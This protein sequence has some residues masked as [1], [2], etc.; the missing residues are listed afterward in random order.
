MLI[1][2]RPPPSLHRARL[3]SLRQIKLG[4]SFSS[5]GS[6]SLCPRT[7]QAWL[8]GRIPTAK[9]NHFV[10][11][12][13]RSPFLHA[14]GAWTWWRTR[15]LS[16]TQAYSH[17]CAPSFPRWSTCYYKR[18]C[19]SLTSRARRCR[20]APRRIEALRSPASQIFVRNSQVLPRSNRYRR[21]LLNWLRRSAETLKSRFPTRV[22]TSAWMRQI[23]CL[24]P[25][26]DPGRWKC[27][28]ARWMRCASSRDPCPSTSSGSTWR[29]G[30]RT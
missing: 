3:T 24:C 15:C 10:R 29:P 13:S 16:C 19:Q 17:K 21:R 25:C 1:E 30:R 23:E 8:Q 9:F 14:V 20:Q 28:L 4:A 22:Q 18:S 5:G 11:R 2:L 27:H 6:R 12:H 26:R 7:S